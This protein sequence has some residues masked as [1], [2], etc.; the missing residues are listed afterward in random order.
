VRVVRCGRYML[1]VQ[2]G[3]DGRHELSLM[4]INFMQSCCYL[5]SPLFAS[6]FV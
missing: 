6:V 4:S 5:Q 3:Y 2:V 1:A